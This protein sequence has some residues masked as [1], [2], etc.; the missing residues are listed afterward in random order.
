MA[1]KIS[2]SASA[3]RNID[4]PD[5]QIGR[6]ILKFLHERI[7]PLEDPRRIGDALPAMMLNPVLYNSSHPQ[8]LFF[9]L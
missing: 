5:I 6:R 1:W 3:K 2:L 7:S 9:H 8:S 4:K